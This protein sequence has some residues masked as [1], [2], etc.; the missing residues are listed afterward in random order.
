MEERHALALVRRACAAGGDSIALREDVS[1]QLMRYLRADA[2]CA[3]EI[4]P[5]TTLPVHDVNHGWPR[6]YVTPL[7]ENALF[8]SRTADT[9]FLTRHTRRAL[10]LDELLGSASP[11]QDPYFQHHVLPFGYRHEI[12]FMCVAGGLPRALFTFNRRS[13]RGPF[14]GR[15][16]RLLEAVAP[17]VGAAMHAACVRSALVERPAP[18]TGLIVLGPDGTVEQTNRVGA[19]LLGPGTKQA[20][21]LGLDV[22]L[23]LMRRSLREGKPPPVTTMSLTDPSTQ[24]SYRLI[25]EHSIA[26]D[27]LARALVL[28]E[29][30]RPIDSEIGLLR[31]GLTAREALVVGEV[32]RDESIVACAARLGC[33]PA[34][35]TRHLKNVFGKLAVGSRRELALRLLG[36]PPNVTPSPR[37]LP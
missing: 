13:E 32:L 17:H 2:Y 33:A 35:V 26:R 9:G 14:E 15:H 16:L 6:E 10:I 5:F 21:L 25:G 12:Q 7:V 24:S 34:T 1:K 22:F 31:L 11:K 30:A 19:R 8:A 18:E 36:T 27:G 20:S 3:M 37:G 28:L 29:P 4:D 23:G